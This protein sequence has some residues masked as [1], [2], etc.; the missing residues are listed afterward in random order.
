MLVQPRLQHC[1]MAQQKSRF[2]AN[3]IHC[4]LQSNAKWKWPVP[5]T[6]YALKCRG[7]SPEASIT[8]A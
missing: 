8:C 2:V 5:K 1:S 4:A 7:C 6:S 3:R